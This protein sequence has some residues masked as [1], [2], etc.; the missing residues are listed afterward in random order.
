MARTRS[1]T[2]VGLVIL[3]E[4]RRRGQLVPPASG[5]RFSNVAQRVRRCLH[6]HAPVLALPRASAGSWQV[7]VFPIRIRRGSVRFCTASGA[8]R[9]E[10]HGARW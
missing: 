7:C 10:D 1:E 3:A 5:W 6:G 9:C 4:A 2:P 8:A